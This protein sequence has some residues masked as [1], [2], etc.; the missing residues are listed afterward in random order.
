MDGTYRQARRAVLPNRFFLRNC[1]IY[2]SDSFSYCQFDPVNK[3]FSSYC[4]FD[5]VNKCFSSYCQFSEFVRQSSPVYLFVC[6]ST[7]VVSQSV[8]QICWFGRSTFNLDDY[9]RESVLVRNAYKF[10]SI[11]NIWYCAAYI[12]FCFPFFF[13]FSQSSFFKRK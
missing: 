12:S 4:Q 10:K 1:Q 5:P 6:A 3:C 11:L 13:I 2:S 9:N 7:T 8:S